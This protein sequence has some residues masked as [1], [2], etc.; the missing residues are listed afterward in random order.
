[1]SRDRSAAEVAG[2][3]IL[4]S[5]VEE[6]A[7]LLRRGPAARHVGPS[8]AD[9]WIHRWAV[10]QLIGEAVLDHE[11]RV[12]PG[13]PDPDDPAGAIRRLVARVTE[14]VRIPE[15]VVRSF[16]ERN[17]DRYR[18][19]ERRRVTYASFADGRAAARA[20]RR[21]AAGAEPMRDGDRWS[22]MKL[23]RGDYVGPFEAAVFAAHVGDVVGPMPVDHGWLV[24]RVDEIAEASTTPYATVRSAIADELLDV[25][26]ARAFDEW[27]ERRRSE[28]SRV[29]PAYEHPA[30][31]VHGQPRHRH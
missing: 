3:A 6:R 22:S 23:S 26:R 31:P 1:V 13:S 24:A 17:L 21:L 25:A 4:V 28:L 15:A 7:S 30:H 27:M 9:D 16:Y 19:P 20:R 12:P 2:R 29:T 8:A 18:S 11:L 10:Q 14:P 5:D